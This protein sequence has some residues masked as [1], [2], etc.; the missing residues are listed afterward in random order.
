[1]PLAPTIDATATIRRATAITNR[2]VAQL[3]R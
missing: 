2:V 1:V 3:D